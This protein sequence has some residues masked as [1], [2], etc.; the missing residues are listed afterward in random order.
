M[1]TL[2]VAAIL[3]AIA[4]PRFNDLAASHRLS[5]TA[6]SF[7]HILGTAR[8][9]AIKRNA[10]VIVGVDGSVTV[11]TGIPAVTT[12]LSAA[13]P[14][15]APEI[16]LNIPAAL[17][18]TAKGMLTTGGTVGFTGLVADVSSTQIPTNNH[19]CVYVVTGMTVMSCTD[20]TTCAGGAPSATCK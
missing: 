6:S 11:T 19:R 4:I 16:N 2:T 20:S 14:V 13:I 8:S 7:L 3:L 10:D 5:T 17:T 15:Q 9:E 12:T 1:I 18:A